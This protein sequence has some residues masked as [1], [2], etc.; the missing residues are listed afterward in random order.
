[1]YNKTAKV[2]FTSFN[3][4]LNDLYLVLSLTG[5]AEENVSSVFISREENERILFERYN[6]TQNA[7]LVQLIY[8]HRLVKSF[9]FR[10][11]KTV[12]VSNCV[13]NHVDFNDCANSNLVLCFAGML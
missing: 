9:W 5:E 11:Y 2:F 1:M 12:L 8:Y 10:E 3:P 7:F 4:T 6:S 13:A